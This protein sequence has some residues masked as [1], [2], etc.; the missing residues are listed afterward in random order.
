MSFELYYFFT[1]LDSM[2]SFIES[3]YTYG[4]ERFST[5]CVRQTYMRFTFHCVII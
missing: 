5:Y 1:N 2:D 3:E 4:F